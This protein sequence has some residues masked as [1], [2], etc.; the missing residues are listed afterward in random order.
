ME[1]HALREK[2]RT[3]S[4]ELNNLQVVLTIQS[5]DLKAQETLAKGRA[6]KLEAETARNHHL[7]TLLYS[8]RAQ[9]LLPKGK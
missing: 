2:L 9:N 4:L 6:N 8:K 3:V 7:A 5:E 1:T